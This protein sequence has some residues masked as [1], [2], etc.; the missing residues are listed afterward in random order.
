MNQRTETRGVKPAIRPEEYRER[1]NISLPG[2]LKEKA[3]IIGGGNFSAGVA[4]ALDKFDLKMG[5]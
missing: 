4:L 1:S 3:R 5:V 2:S